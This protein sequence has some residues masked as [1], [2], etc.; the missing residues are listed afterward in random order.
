RKISTDVM[1]MTVIQRVR[2]LS[3]R[4]ARMP[5]VGAGPPSASRR[6]LTGGPRSQG[7]RTPWADALV[8]CHPR[9]QPN[10]QPSAPTTRVA[11]VGRVAGGD[12]PT[13]PYRHSW[14]ARANTP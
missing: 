8:S 4:D 1:A 2:T 11:G 13:V 7:S 12:W 6:S 10:Y 9:V 5:G 14:R 3:N